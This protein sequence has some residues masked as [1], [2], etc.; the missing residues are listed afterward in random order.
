MFVNVTAEELIKGHQ[1][2]LIRLIIR[3]SV[4]IQVG[5]SLKFPERPTFATSEP[6]AWHTNCDPTA[7]SVGKYA[8]RL[9]TGKA[10]GIFLR[11]ATFEAMYP[12]LHIS[13]AK[14]RLKDFFFKK[15]KKIFRL[16]SSTSVD[17]LCSNKFPEP[18]EDTHRYSHSSSLILF[19]A[20]HI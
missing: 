16:R 6:Q 8:R 10:A 18:K 9:T 4:L 12:H 11:L 5:R 15:S 17:L 14:K 7:S 3:I 13:W 20:T 1:V 19:Y 2:K